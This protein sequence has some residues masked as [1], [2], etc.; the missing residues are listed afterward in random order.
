MDTDFSNTD[1]IEN[2]T[3]FSNTDFIEN[4]SN[5]ANRFVLLYFWSGNVLLIQ[6]LLKAKEQKIFFENKTKIII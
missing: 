1:C 3:D 6:Q 2:C 5:E 4:G